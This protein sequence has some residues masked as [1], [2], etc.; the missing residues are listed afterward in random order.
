M[1]PDWGICFSCTS[2]GTSPMHKNRINNDSK[3]NSKVFPKW[4][5]DTGVNIC[6]IKYGNAILWWSIVP[7]A[8]QLETVDPRNFLKRNVRGKNSHK[9]PS[10]VVL[11]WINVWN[12][13]VSSAPLG[14][15]QLLHHGCFYMLY[16]S[17]LLFLS[18][19]LLYPP[20]SSSI[21]SPLQ[22]GSNQGFFLLKLPFSKKKTKTTTKKKQFRFS[23]QGGETGGRR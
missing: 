12:T 19:P 3:R 20:F 14:H 18:F 11:P 6:N 15:S 17:I 7:R 23:D 2:G 4:L 13:D 10:Y 21:P 8:S 16:V 22:P 9:C 5:K 1:E